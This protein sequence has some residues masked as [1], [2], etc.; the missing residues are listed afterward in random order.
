MINYYLVL[1]VDKNADPDKIKHAYR[2]YCKRYHPDLASKEENSNFLKIQEAYETLSDKEKRKIY[3]RNLEREKSQIPVNFVNA[4]FWQEEQIQNRSIKRSSLIFDTLF[5]GFFPDFYE[6]DFSD[7]EKLYLELN[8]SAGEA[9]AG[10][11]F[12]IEIPE[13][14]EC[15]VCLGKGYINRSICIFCN[16]SGKIYKNRSFILHV[17]PDVASGYRTEVFLDGNGAQEVFVNI[18]IVV[19]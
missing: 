4:G 18:E 3:D 10:G 13:M 8:L 12:P 19:N 14:K 15:S 16:G 1:G 11:N 9:K 5:D 6:N 7:E 17:P 2:F